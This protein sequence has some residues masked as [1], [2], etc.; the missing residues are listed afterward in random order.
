MLRGGGCG[1]FHI[2]SH[3]RLWQDA[4]LEPP[5]PFD[6]IC[7]GLSSNNDADHWKTPHGDAWKR[8]G[9]HLFIF[10]AANK[11]VIHIFVFFLTLTDD[12][13]RNVDG[14]SGLRIEFPNKSCWSCVLVFNFSEV[15]Y[16][17]IF[18]WGCVSMRFICNINTSVQR[19]AGWRK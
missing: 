9:E 3:Y 6:L 16:A 2:G 4:N 8:T 10:S 17:V 11:I 14:T 5:A 7:V 18:P 12:A 15:G 19:R 1:K 13:P